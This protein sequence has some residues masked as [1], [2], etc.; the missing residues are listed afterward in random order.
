MQGNLRLKKSN[1]RIIAYGT[2]DEANASL[3]IVL[4]NKLDSDIF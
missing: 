3:G 2:I 4:A 1:P